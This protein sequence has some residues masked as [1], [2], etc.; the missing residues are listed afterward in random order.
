MPRLL[1][2]HMLRLSTKAACTLAN[3]GGDPN[4]GRRYGHAD[5]ENMNWSLHFSGKNGDL[6]LGGEFGMGLSLVFFFNKQ[7]LPFLFVQIE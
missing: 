6:G 3:R 7:L 4:L 2:Q 5:A 1:F